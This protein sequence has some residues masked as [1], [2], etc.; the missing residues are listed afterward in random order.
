MEHIKICGSHNN[1]QANR[2]GACLTLEVSTSET[3]KTFEEVEPNWQNE[4]HKL[5]IGARIILCT[6][7]KLEHVLIFAVL[8]WAKVRYFMDCK[9]YGNCR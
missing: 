1:E 5:A 3:R 9:S 7:Q 2:G 8:W 4:K 6:L